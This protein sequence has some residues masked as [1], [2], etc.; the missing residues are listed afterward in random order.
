[1]DFR[2]VLSQDD[3]AQYHKDGY[4]DVEIQNALDSATNSQLK[5]TYDPSQQQNTDPRRLASN[6]YIAGAYNE[7][8]IQWQLELD[9]ILERIEHMLRGDQPTFNNGS[10][11]WTPPQDKNEEILNHYGVAEVMR[12]L[13]NYV[14]RNTVLSNY[15]EDT[16]N[17]K[18]LDL[19]RELKDLFY[20]KYEAFGWDTLEKRKLYPIIVRELIDVCHSAYLRALHGGER[21]SLREARTVSQ[22]DNGM[23][24]ININTAPQ[25]RERG[26]FNPL[27]Y[28]GNK[29][30]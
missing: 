5:T 17:D 26:I 30:K 12:V 19:G 11:M 15:D 16:I 29:F 22:T 2:Q 24:G 14:N 4:T 20:L 10:I 21:E 27:R 7:N 1:M 8:L 25:M 3:I 28:I 13:S 23:G 6:S 18:L 9:S